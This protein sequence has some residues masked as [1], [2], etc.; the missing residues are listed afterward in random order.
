MAK[1]VKRGDIDEKAIIASFMQ[2]EPADH[3][4]LIREREGDG[5]SEPSEAVREETRRLRSK[6]QD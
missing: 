4:A 1:T 6:E 2:D 3:D 5:S